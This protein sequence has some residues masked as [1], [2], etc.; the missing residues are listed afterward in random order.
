M[1]TLKHSKETF[2]SLKRCLRP[3][4]VEKCDS[5]FCR[6]IAKEYVATDQIDEL[7]GTEESKGTAASK[8]RVRQSNRFGG[9]G[10]ITRMMLNSLHKNKE[11]LDQ[12]LTL[13]NIHSQKVTKIPQDIEPSRKQEMIKQL[14]PKL[15]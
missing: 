11:V 12:I 15:E 3:G 5:P 7:R 10:T 14:I 4:V 2:D 6:Y 8:F 13:M 1:K 9:K